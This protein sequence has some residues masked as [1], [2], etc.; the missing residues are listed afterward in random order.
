LPKST[1]ESRQVVQ[2]I[3]VGGAC[4]NVSFIWVRGTTEP[5]NIVSSPSGLFHL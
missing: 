2:D 4:K 1:L 3:T 5:A